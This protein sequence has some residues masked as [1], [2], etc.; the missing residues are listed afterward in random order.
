MHTRL[1]HVYVYWYS[2]FWL[3]LHVYKTK[4]R[5]FRVIHAWNAR[6]RRLLVCVGCVVG[7]D[8]GKIGRYFIYPRAKSSWLFPHP[9]LIHLHWTLPQHGFVKSPSTLKN[10]FP[11]TTISSHMVSDIF[12]H[13][14]TPQNLWKN[15]EKTGFFIEIFCLYTI[16]SH[17]LT[18]DIG[19]KSYW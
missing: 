10:C 11:T 15:G 7:E 9:L 6:V 13:P 5:F 19:I 2:I 14:W 1:H 16:F 8:N 12:S 17:T 3:F 4:T 18:T